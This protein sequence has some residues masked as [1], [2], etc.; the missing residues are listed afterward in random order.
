[1]K[2]NILLE[3]LSKATLIL[4]NQKK[5]ITDLKDRVSAY[6]DHYVQATD[7]HAIFDESQEG[8]DDHINELE[9]E[10]A[11]I[12]METIQALLDLLGDE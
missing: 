6:H 3:E 11:S 2:I 12:I 1:M 9:R 8:Y 10:G 7:D 5:Q 4:S